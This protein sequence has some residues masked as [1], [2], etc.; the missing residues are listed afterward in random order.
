M[1]PP[2]QQPRGVA[3]CHPDRVDQA[4][5]TVEMDSQRISASGDLDVQPVIVGHGV[6]RVGADDVR[7][8]RVAADIARSDRANA[9]EAPAPATQAR[10]PPLLWTRGVTRPW[11]LTLQW[12]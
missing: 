2:S 3:T 4:A 8:R 5:P 10:P 11:P 6:L 12:T 7:M 9:A 1:A